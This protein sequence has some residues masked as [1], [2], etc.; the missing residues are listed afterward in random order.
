MVS[1]VIDFPLHGTSQ[2]LLQSNQIHFLLMDSTGRTQTLQQ[3]FPPLQFVS[4]LPHMP[5][6]MPSNSLFRFQQ[7]RIECMHI[8]HG[9]LRCGR[10]GRC[11]KIRHIITDSGVCLMTH[12]RNDRNPAVENCLCHNLLVKCPQILHRAA[13]TPNDHHI[14]AIFLQR[15]DSLHDAGSRHIPLHDGR[16]QYNLHIRIPSR[17]NLDN[18]PDRRA[19]R[20]RYNP[21]RPDKSGNRLLIFLREHSHLG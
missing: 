13:A 1:S 11:P 5:H 6:H 8:Q 21:Q 2:F 9:K 12:C 10:R 20:S 4:T 3:Q 19:R 17:C 7:S 16:I 18:I 14:H 15:A